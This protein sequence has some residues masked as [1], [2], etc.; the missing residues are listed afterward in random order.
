M[1]IEVQRRGKSITDC[2][3]CIL[4][5]DMITNI[6]FLHSRVVYI[7]DLII[8]LLYS[9]CNRREFYIWNNMWQSLL[10]HHAF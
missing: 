3:L 1:N 9:A 4:Y 2:M 8:K 5:V 10:L 7:K 6:H